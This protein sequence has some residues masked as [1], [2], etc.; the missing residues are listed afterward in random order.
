MGL[1]L[2]ILL[3]HSVPFPAAI[4]AAAACQPQP[5]QTL[6]VRVRV[7]ARVCVCV[8]AGGVRRLL[9]SIESR[10][11]YSLPLFPL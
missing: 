4:A 5:R 2:C 6:L 7:R 1:S 3:P 9:S 8:C 10:Q 11:I